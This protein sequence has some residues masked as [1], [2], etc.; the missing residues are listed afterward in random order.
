MSA[1]KKLKATGI[2][3]DVPVTLLCESCR[4]DNC[5]NV[6]QA[7]TIAA[8]TLQSMCVALTP[9]ADRRRLQT[10][11]VRSAC[12]RVVKACCAGPDRITS[13]DSSREAG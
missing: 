6:L 9:R 4:G 3:V 11:I 7:Q 10:V 5:H 2:P 12:R 13:K 1:C 8:R